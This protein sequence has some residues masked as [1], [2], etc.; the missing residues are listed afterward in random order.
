[1]RSRLRGE[2]RENVLVTCIPIMAYTLHTALSHLDKRNTYV[3]LLFIDYSSA[4]NTIVPSS[5]S[6]SSRPMG[7]HPILCNW[8]QDFLKG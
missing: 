3:R 6:L 8:V 5:S 2:D 1:M 4:F 7:L